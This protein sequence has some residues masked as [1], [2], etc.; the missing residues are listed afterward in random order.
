[1]SS[2]LSQTKGKGLNKTIDL[3]QEHTAMKYTL[4]K[5]RTW[6]K[7]MPV[8]APMYV[9][10][11]NM[12]GTSPAELECLA[13]SLKNSPRKFKAG[14]AKHTKNASSL[15]PKSSFSIKMATQNAG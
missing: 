4:P 11:K 5:T 13:N 12:E 6:K 15:Q 3:F 8:P 10:L 7:Q 2:Q 1:M 14:K 9:N